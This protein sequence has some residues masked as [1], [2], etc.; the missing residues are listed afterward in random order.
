[1]SFFVS[2]YSR[3]LIRS[4]L[5]LILIGMC[6]SPVN[7]LA[8]TTTLAASPFETYVS[9]DGEPARLLDIVKTA[10]NRANIDLELRVM[11]EAFL[12]SAVITG[13]VDGEFAYIDLGQNRDDVIVSDVY[14]PIYL[15]AV[16]KRDDIENVSLFPHLKGNRVAIENRFA[17]TPA[18]RMLKEVKWSRNPSTFDAFRQLADDRAPYLITTTLLAQDFNA[19]L[20]NDNEELLHFSAKPLLTTGF[21]IAIN[22]HASKAKEIIDAFNTAIQFMQKDGEF[23]VLLAKAWLTKDVN[24]DGIADYI[25]H[26]S[27][28][29]AQHHTSAAF[30]LDGKATSTKSLYVIDGKSYESLD[31]A[32]EAL[33]AVDVVAKPVSLLDEST[34]RPLIRSW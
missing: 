29:K 33:T 6:L 22:K 21:R 2:G 12:G 30:S 26:S 32:H 17:N 8:A 34:Y 19:L 18:F 9:D 5:V 23:N 10:F 7:T 28:T 11:R 31:D 1:M 15:V 27:I 3:L 16:S 20:E 14:L 24:N 25:G 4:P 13:S